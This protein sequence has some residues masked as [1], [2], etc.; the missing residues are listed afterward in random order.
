MTNSKDKI[1]VTSEVGGS[2][3]D[4]V[5][6]GTQRT[7]MVMVSALNWGVGTQVFTLLPLCCSHF[8]HDQLDLHSI[9]IKPIR[10]QVV[11]QSTGEL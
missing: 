4:G 6:K 11:G 9:V 1:A 3:M 5:G 8:I 2:G 10:D 7:S